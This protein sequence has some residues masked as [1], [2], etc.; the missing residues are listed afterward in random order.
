MCSSSAWVETAKIVPKEP[1]AFISLSLRWRKRET[2]QTLLRNEKPQLAQHARPQYRFRAL[3]R[4]P[5]RQS[6]SSL[7]PPFAHTHP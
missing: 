1:L 2:R 7:E 6:G 5:L 4:D 3:P